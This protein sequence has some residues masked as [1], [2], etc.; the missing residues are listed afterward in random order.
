MPSFTKKAIVESFL[1]LLAKKPPEK[2][3]VR[4]VVDD[5]GINRNTFYYYFQDIYAVLEELCKS[6]VTAIPEGL[7]L[8]ETLAAVFRTLAEFAGKNPRAVHNLVISTGLDGMERNF[9]LPLEGAVNAA[10]E[11]EAP[12]LTPAETTLLSHSVRHAFIGVC[13]EYFWRGMKEDRETVADEIARVYS[14]MV[15]SFIPDK[16]A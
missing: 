3:T 16:K 15:K 11:R 7:D 14:G 2:I 4:D 12:A 13:F 1:R 8:G 6:A 9:F 10:I 5:C